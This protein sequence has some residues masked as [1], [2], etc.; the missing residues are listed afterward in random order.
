MSAIDIEE[1]SQNNIVI[2]FD[3]DLSIV[4]IKMT[5]EKDV[6][7]TLILDLQWFM[8]MEQCFWKKM[9]KFWH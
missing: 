2:I 6:K 1:T 3:V 9:I 5:S 8:V 4:N 7:K